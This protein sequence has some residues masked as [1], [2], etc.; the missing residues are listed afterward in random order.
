M[1]THDTGGC[2]VLAPYQPPPPANPA[3][4][5]QWAEPGPG[6][7]ASSHLSSSLRFKHAI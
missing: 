5:R 6:P 3:P 4:G 1:T 2:E 7:S